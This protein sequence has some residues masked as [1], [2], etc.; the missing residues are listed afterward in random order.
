MSKGE[1]GEE[2]KKGK[3]RGGKEN[4]GG[5][6]LHPISVMLKSQD[7]VSAGALLCQSFTDFSE[8]AIYR[9]N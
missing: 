4:Q 8:V 7:V 2:E 5:Q 9:N 1:K 3:E 6:Y